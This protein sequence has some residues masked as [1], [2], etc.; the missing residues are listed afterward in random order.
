MWAYLLG[1]QR[2]RNTFTCLFLKLTVT[3]YNLNLHTS[4]RLI[5]LRL[6]SGPFPFPHA[7]API[8]PHLSHYPNQPGRGGPMEGV[9]CVPECYQF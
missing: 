3:T 2:C 7:P 9:A 1:G 5:S 8:L 4:P 6:V